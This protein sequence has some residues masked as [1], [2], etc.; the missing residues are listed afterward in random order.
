MSVVKILAK[1]VPIC[2]YMYVAQSTQR[3]TGNFGLQDIVYTGRK[4]SSSTET[5]FL[6]C[7]NFF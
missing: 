7:P 6:R 3:N 5:Y 1:S 2:I 4:A